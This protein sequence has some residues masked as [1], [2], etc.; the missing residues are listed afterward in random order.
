MLV[1]RNKKIGHERGCFMRE[2]RLI[3]GEERS[4][5]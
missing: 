1:I 2:R 4:M 3:A 5:P